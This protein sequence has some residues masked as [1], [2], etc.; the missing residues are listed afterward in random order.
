MKKML[1]TVTYLRLEEDTAIHSSVLTWIIPWM[2]GYSP[3]GHRVRYGCTDRALMHA[4]LG[5]L[6]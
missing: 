4:Q 5:L 1:L 3:W 2:V 6:L